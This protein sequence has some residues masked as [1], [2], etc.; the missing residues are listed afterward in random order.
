MRQRYL[1]KI[2]F[3]CLIFFIMF[4]FF[5][6]FSAI[7]FITYQNSF[8]FD[9]IQNYM[10]P[11]S[12]LEKLKEEYDFATGFIWHLK[13]RDEIGAR[14]VGKTTKNAKLAIFGDSYTWSSE[15]SDKEAWGYFLTHN[16]SVL[17]ANFG[18]A[19][20]GTDQAYL[21]Y[22]QKKDVVNAEIYALG[23]ITE[24][25]NRVFNVYRPFYNNAAHGQA[26]TK[27]S[28]YLDDEGSLQFSPNPLLSKEDI[29]KLRDVSFL[30]TLGEKD[31]WYENSQKPTLSFPYSRL[32]FHRSIVQEIIYGK[33]DD[34]N[35]KA[36][37]NL[38][39]SEYHKD[40]MFKLFDAFVEDVTLQNKTAIIYIVP[41]IGEVR[42]AYR[43]NTAFENELILDYCRHKNYTC[44]SGL[45]AFVQNITTSEDIENLYNHREK[46]GSYRIGHP[47]QRGNEVFAIAFYDF[48][49]SKEL[50]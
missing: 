48:L 12:R 47:N 36:R 19:G 41:R 29:G 24:N 15:V 14:P 7:F 30:R 3:T 49:V 23:L 40:V 46:D 26:L 17:T 8:S 18:V 35:T 22:L 37:P 28:A 42:Q 6:L 31:F 20:Y 38:W 39:K 9:T 34:A 27:P 2:M 10:P 25:I 13:N 44:F 45:D 4:I 32:F 21:L 1:K 33:P 16:R 50:V 5:E 43:G 11:E